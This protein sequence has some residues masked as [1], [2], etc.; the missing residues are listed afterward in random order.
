MKLARI[1]CLAWSWP[2]LSLGSL[3][4]WLETAQVVLMVAGCSQLFSFLGASRILS[5]HWRYEKKLGGPSRKGL[6]WAGSITIAICL[7]SLC[8]PQVPQGKLCKNKQA[9]RPTVPVQANCAVLTWLVLVRPWDSACARRQ[10]RTHQTRNESGGQEPTRSFVALCLLRR[11]QL[12]YFLIL[13][14]SKAVV[15]GSKKKK[16]NRSVGVFQIRELWRMLPSWSD[17][18]VT[19]EAARRRGMIKCSNFWH[20]TL[21][22]NLSGTYTD[23]V[24]VGLF[25]G[26]ILFVITVE[27][28]P[29]L[30]IWVKFS[31]TVMIHVKV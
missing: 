3:G 24:C 29:P 22:F 18:Q 25:A 26:E 11:R 19:E 14:Y 10:S 2:V 28:N 5:H 4:I 23:Y 16:L 8:S 21:R 20:P 31:L 13:E 7:I 15:T 6:L 12:H 30:F 9:R 27:P 1:T 17:K